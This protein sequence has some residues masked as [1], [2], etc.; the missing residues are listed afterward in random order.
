LTVL[1]IDLA[2]IGIVVFCGWRGY[3]NGLIRGV[4][5]VVALILSIFGANIIAK[6]YSGEFTEMLQPFIGGVVDTAL[7][8]IVEQNVEFDLSPLDDLGLGESGEK[9]EFLDT[10]FA[11]L[12]HLGL[13]EPSA[14][15]VA[16]QATEDDIPSGVV[17]SDF[18]AAKLS[19]ALA[20]IAVFTI[21][22][23]LLAI[24]FAVIGNLVGFVFSLPGLRIVDMAAGALLGILK[25]LLIV[26]TL[27]VIVRYAG[28]FAPRTIEE[29]TVLNRIVLSNPIA[30]LLGL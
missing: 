7:V 27:A 9:P 5:G 10:A 11:A 12:R 13:P 17:L 15:R 28:I 18:I 29:T 30:E 1:A 14:A 24:I 2:I 21:A 23:I 25:G 8:E 20:F 6:A 19:I 3:K 4:F 22:F 26:L 16:S